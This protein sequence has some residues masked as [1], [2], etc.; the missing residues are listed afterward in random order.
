[1]VASATHCTGRRGG[2]RRS[3]C[4]PCRSGP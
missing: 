1:V 2:G 3:C 4:T